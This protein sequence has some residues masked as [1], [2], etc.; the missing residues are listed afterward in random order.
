[1]SKAATVPFFNS[2][3]SLI[4]RAINVLPTCGRGEQMM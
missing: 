3:N 4:S 2:W 1:M